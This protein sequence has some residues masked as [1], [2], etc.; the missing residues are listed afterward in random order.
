MAQKHEL[1]R[2]GEDAAVIYLRHKG[3]EILERNWRT[4]HLELDI[5]ARHENEL[6]V[7]EVKTRQADLEQLPQ[8]AVS[9]AKMQRVVKAA[10]IY[11]QQYGQDLDLR[12]DFIMVTVE[13]DGRMSIYHAEN[14][15]HPALY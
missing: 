13:A 8:E 12:V 2:A 6:V 14:G 10:N 9:L 15:L 4:G 1:G 7:V 5:V 11:A 3:Y